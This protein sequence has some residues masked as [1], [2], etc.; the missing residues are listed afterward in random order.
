MNQLVMELQCSKCRRNEIKLYCRTFPTHSSEVIRLGGEDGKPKLAKF[1]TEMREIEWTEADRNDA[2]QSIMM[3]RELNM[4]VM[5]ERQSDNWG[6]Q[7]ENGKKY[8]REREMHGNSMEDLR[9]V[10]PKIQ[11]EMKPP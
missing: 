6:I 1:G 7:Q 2:R 4:K 3:L 11:G 8:K 9:M 10:L 5:E